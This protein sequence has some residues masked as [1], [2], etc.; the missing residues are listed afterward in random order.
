MVETSIVLKGGR[1]V[2]T[3]AGQKLKHCL[4]SNGMVETS[5]V[6]KGGRKVDTGAGQK[7]QHF[8]LAYNY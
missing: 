3:G 8:C 4:F 6:L 2:D 7:L 1:K 5:I